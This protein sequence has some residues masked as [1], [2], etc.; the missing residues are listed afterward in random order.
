M[1]KDEFKQLIKESVREVLLTE[2]FL[3]TIVS[4]VVKGIGTNVVTE[5]VT[6][7]QQPDA[8][9]EKTKQDK[10]A[11]M[12]QEEKMKSLK[13]TKRKML[14]AIGKNAYGGIDLFEGTAPMRGGGNVGA[15]SAPNSSL[16]DIEP[17]DPGVDISA[18]MGST[19]AW[20]EMIK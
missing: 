15:P 3:S 6:A 1:K 7:T 4:E 12:R 2:G 19:G 9:A 11:Q 18:L 13:E 8:K 16:G 20:K 17:G 10:M 14:D 5:R